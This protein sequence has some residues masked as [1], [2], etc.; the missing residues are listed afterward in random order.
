MG[1]GLM[2]NGD[3]KATQLVTM[4]AGFPDET[5]LDFKLILVPVGDVTKG[6]QRGSFRV[7]PVSFVNY[8]TYSIT[9]QT[10]GCIGLIG[11]KNAAPFLQ[12]IQNY[13]QTHSFI[14]L[15]V[16]IIGNENV[17]KQLGKK[18]NYQ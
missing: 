16:S 4:N 14:M 6:L 15:N 9:G 5:G 1:N 2:P 7:H 12:Y 11:N 18:S 3:Y 8:G 17:K 10:E 13:Y